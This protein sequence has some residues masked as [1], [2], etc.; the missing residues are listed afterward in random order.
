M[1]GTSQEGNRDTDAQGGLMRTGQ[2][3]K[4]PVR[5]KIKYHVPSWLRNNEAS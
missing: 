2:L 4:L 5:Y 3:Q 1:G